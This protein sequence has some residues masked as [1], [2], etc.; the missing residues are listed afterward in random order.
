MDKL[1]IGVTANEG[2]TRQRNRHVPWTSA[3]IALDAARC[4]EQGAAI[5]HYHVRTEEGAFDHSAQACASTIAQVKA[6][7]DILQVPALASTPGATAADRLANVLPGAVDPRTRPD[8]IAV[9]PGCANMDLFDPVGQALLSTDRTLINTFATVRFMLQRLREHGISP[10][11]ASFNVSWT[12]AIEALLATGDITSPMLL[13]LVLGGPS[14]IA[15]HPANVAGLNAHLAFL[16]R[17]ATIHWL[18]SCHGANALEVA[19]AAIE[20]GGHIAL[21]LG[22]HPYDELGE[23]TNADLVARVCQL[24]RERGREPATPAE[25]RQLLAKA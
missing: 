16:P 21:G 19:A 3:D 7:C 2:A 4:R 17:G 15:A 8:F 25:V 12:R 9:E 11:F 6:R 20:A 22:D 5:V 24:A 10:Y 1:I 23:P 18:T 14:F 13:M